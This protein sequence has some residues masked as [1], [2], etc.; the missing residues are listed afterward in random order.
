MGLTQWA[1]GQQRGSRDTFVCKSKMID[2]SASTLGALSA[3]D[4]VQNK[5]KL[6]PNMHVATMIRS[7]SSTPTVGF[8]NYRRN[9]FWNPSPKVREPH[10]LWFGLSDIHMV[11]MRNFSVI[12]AP[13][14]FEDH[15]NAH[16]R[17]TAMPHCKKIG[18]LVSTSFFSKLRRRR[19]KVL[20]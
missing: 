6:L 3:A 9:R 20:L 4:F 14:I 12:L 2:V 5:P 19:G 17:Q 10:F 7:S 15:G 1:L 8:A 11:T 13:S 16:G 18:G